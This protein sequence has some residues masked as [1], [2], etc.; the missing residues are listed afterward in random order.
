MIYKEASTCV[1][2][3]FNED[4]YDLHQF[5][6]DSGN[7]VSSR[8]G[9][10]MEILNFKTVLKNPIKR[11]VGGHK[12]NINVFF[13]LAEA[14]WIFCGRKDVLFLDTFNSQLKQYSDDGVTYH[15]PYGWRLRNWGVDS[16]I[17]ITE[18]N[19]HSVHG[20]D[21]LF[22]VVKMLD[23]NPEDRRVVMSVWNPELDLNV[24]CNDLPCND[25]IMYKIRNGK[26]Y[27]TISNRSNDLNL[28][29]TTNVFQFS[30][31][32]EII[33]KVLGVGLG[34]QVHNSQSLHLYLNHP[35][36]DALSDDIRRYNHFY[37]GLLYDHAVAIDM[38]FSFSSDHTAK[39][40]FL[41]IDFHIRSIVSILLNKMRNIHHY[42][43]GTNDVLAESINSEFKQYLD[44]LKE[45]SRYLYFV[46]KILDIYIEYKDNKS[47]A[48]SL[49]ELIGLSLELPEFEKSDYMLLALNF[50]A[51]RLTSQAGIEIFN[52][53]METSNMVNVGNY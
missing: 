40:K 18:E 22:E 1:A 11:C 20:I 4:Y 5:L 51:V 26:L 3:H 28:G 24:K 13:L 35:M 7:S 37:N 41:L 49:K 46:Y 50:F 15:A 30:F 27:S 31:I 38:D 44:S 36:T 25:L 52:E 21:Q 43:L 39:Q 32:T 29:L 45:F 16:N 17:N 34:D 6:L 2:E 47:K 14:L 8:N 12:R 33:A 53:I 10:T 42:E 19:K 48:F 23:A 9:S